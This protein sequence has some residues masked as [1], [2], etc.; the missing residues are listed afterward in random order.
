MA[1]VG[2]PARNPEHFARDG[3]KWPQAAAVT[4]LRKI[5]WQV[6]DGRERCPPDDPAIP[7]RPDVPLDTAAI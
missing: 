4:G 3:E 2:T 1:I 7:L 5:G 6:D